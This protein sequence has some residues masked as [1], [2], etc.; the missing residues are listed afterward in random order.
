M[1]NDL[2]DFTDEGELSHHIIADYTSICWWV[3]C[4]RG[5][6]LVPLGWFCRNSDGRS[7]NSI[8]GPSQDNK[9]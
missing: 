8:C 3:C 5:C 7:P 9:A 2:E 1:R 4:S 6:L